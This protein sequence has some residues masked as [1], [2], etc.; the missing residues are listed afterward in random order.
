M[1]NPFGALVG[2]AWGINSVR[3]PLSP[4]RSGGISPPYVVEP[5]SPTPGLRSRGLRH[6]RILVPPRER[7]RPDAQTICA[8]LFLGPP[9]VVLGPGR[10]DLTC[11]RPCAS[12]A[13]LF[14]VDVCG[15]HELAPRFKI[16]EDAARST[17]G[18]GFCRR[19]LTVTARGPARRRP[20]LSATPF[21]ITRPRVTSPSYG[22]PLGPSVAGANGEPVSRF[23]SLRTQPGDNTEAEGQ[24]RPALTSPSDDNCLYSALRVQGSQ[25]VL[26]CGP[27][28]ARNP[29]PTSAASND[30][31]RPRPESSPSGAPAPCSTGPVLLR[32]DVLPATVHGLFYRARSSDD[33]SD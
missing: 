24:E 4:T 2:D 21:H 11:Y 29:A 22:R 17:R 18:P 15:S 12:S 19:C 25:S 7:S 33:S 3:P 5:C 20:T 26:R 8:G 16:Y 6:P 28:F 31:R 1:L 27:P 23:K 14:Y 32:A 10:L 30:S 9:A 13:M